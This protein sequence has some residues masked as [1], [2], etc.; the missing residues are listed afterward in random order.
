MH[1]GILFGVRTKTFSGISQ[2]M[3]EH[4]GQQR[5]LSDQSRAKLLRPGAAC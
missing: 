5:I 4:S 2:G 1:I 3:D